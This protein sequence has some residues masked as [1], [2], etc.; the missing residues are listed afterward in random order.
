MARRTNTSCLGMAVKAYLLLTVW[1]TVGYALALPVTVVDLMSAQDPPLRLHTAEQY[2]VVYGVPV[3]VALGVA[4]FTRWSRTRP[5]WAYLCHA[6]VVLGASGA[7]V[8]WT[9]TRFDSPEWG[10][11]AMAQSGAAGIAAFLCHRALRWWDGGGFN[12]GRRRPAPGEIWHA[13]VPFRESAGERPH[14]CVVMRSRLRH[15]EVLQI[16]SQDKDHRADHLRIPNDG[17]DFSS[18]KAHWVE[19][20]LPP[21][22]V[23]YGKFTNAMPK[24]RCPKPVWRQLRARRPATGAASALWSRITPTAMARAV[25]G[26]RRR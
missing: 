17:W 18:G 24:G 10:S 19:I 20:G 15:V 14:Y 8:L 9:E 12:G 26:P 13:L 25:R 3:A 4:A 11:R 5:W 1:I 2:A 22:Q 21:R 6:A 16:T 7:A 23:P